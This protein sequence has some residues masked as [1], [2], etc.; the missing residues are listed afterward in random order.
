MEMGTNR[1]ECDWKRHS[2]TPLTYIACQRQRMNSEGEGK[3]Y[4]IRYSVTHN[5]FVLA[6][7]SCRPHSVPLPAQ[8]YRLVP[9]CDECW[10]IRSWSSVQ[11]RYIQSVG[12]QRPLRRLLD[13]ANH[14]QTS[15]PILYD[16]HGTLILGE[17]TAEYVR[18]TERHNNLLWGLVKGR[19]ASS[20]KPRSNWIVYT[21]VGSHDFCEM[22]TYTIWHCGHTYTHDR[23]ETGRRLLIVRPACRFS[24]CQSWQ[25]T[26]ARFDAT[27]RSRSCN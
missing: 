14:R 18:L 23:L 6:L 26:I 9:T 20:I 13:T 5:S 17:I 3:G 7:A 1:W 12:H 15:V 27:S 10:P 16:G 21:I 24:R 2:R 4:S 25:V 22:Y 8:G 19:G 11:W